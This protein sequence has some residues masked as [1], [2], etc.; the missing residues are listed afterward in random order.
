MRIERS[1][2]LLVLL[3]AFLPPT[4]G[5]TIID[6]STSADAAAE[7]HNKNKKN[8]LRGKPASNNNNQNNRNL[9]TTGDYQKWDNNRISTQNPHGVPLNTEGRPDCWG[10]GCASHFMEEVAVE[11]AVE[12]AVE[13]VEEAT[14]TNGGGT[15]EGVVVEQIDQ[16][17]GDGEAATVNVYVV[18]ETTETAATAQ[19]PPVAANPPAEPNR[20]INHDRPVLQKCHLELDEPCTT[21][22]DCRTGCCAEFSPTTRRCKVDEGAIG[23]MFCPD[24]DDN[25][26]VGAGA[27]AGVLDGDLDPSSGAL[28]GGEDRPVPL[29]APL[30]EL[31]EP[32]PIDESS[33]GTGT[34]PATTTATTPQAS[35]TNTQG[36][37][38]PST[39]T[40]N[41]PDG[42]QTLTW[43][44]YT[45][46]GAGITST[47][48]GPATGPPVLGS[49]P[50]AAANN[51]ATPNRLGGTTTE[52]PADC[53]STVDDQGPC[54]F[55][56]QCQSGCCVDYWGGVCV[57]PAVISGRQMVCKP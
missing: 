1:A 36:W 25:E 44:T 35:N 10:T 38:P 16:I 12:V 5:G 3:L 53:S 7:Q 6:G 30:P 23:S 34:I 4:A 39:M 43:G 33:S 56:C 22:S 31:D 47:A 28:G 15:V 13:A 40:A 27:G 26:C 57:D 48:T 42:T 8:N 19:L 24:E 17:D 21:H 18:E 32:V 49:N 55:S 9:L 46:F 45:Q 50:A 29:D 14:A 37:V 52:P 54:Q 51:A 41:L 11:A 20:V 2:V